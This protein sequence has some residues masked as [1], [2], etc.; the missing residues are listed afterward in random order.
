MKMLTSNKLVRMVVMLPFILLY[1]TAVYAAEMDY[2]TLYKEAAPAVVLVYGQN[3]KVGGTGTGSIINQNGLVLTN[4]HVALENMEKKATWKNLF[5]FL[6]PDKITGNPKNDLA[7]RHPARLLAIHP[8]YDLALI[9]IVNPPANLPVL[10]L[11]DLSNIEIGESTVAIGHPSGGAKWTL[12][13]G[14][15]SASWED[16]NRVQGRDVFQ[17]ETSINPG[18]S[19]GPLLDGSMNIIGIN[20]F[21]MRQN[22]SGIALTGLNYAVKST[23]A[24]DWIVSVMGQLPKESLVNKVADKTPPAKPVK[25][26]MIPPAPQVEARNGTQSQERK[27]AIDKGN[28]A[29]KQDSH[30]TVSTEKQGSKSRQV[31]LAQ[32]KAKRKTYHS[33]ARPGV[34]YKESQIDSLQKRMA[35]AFDELDAEVEKMGW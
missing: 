28:H 2:K 22:K 4:A 9:Q 34:E 35:K 18:N 12:T 31:D 32:P 30:R 29:V 6:K 23:T 7:R 33:K 11:S 19:G 17:T 20:T 26:A 13:T 8:E 24:R 16:F 10:P 21:I 1:N 15:L 25:V 14:R 5:V 27:P 3:E